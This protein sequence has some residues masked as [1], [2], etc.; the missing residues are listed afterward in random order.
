MGVR[1]RIR[2]LISL[3]YNKRLAWSRIN[4]IYE[5]IKNESNENVDKYI[6]FIRNIVSLDDSND[7]IRK[8]LKRYCKYTLTEH[9]I[10]KIDTTVTLKDKSEFLVNKYLTNQKALIL[11]EKDFKA[12]FKYQ[13]YNTGYSR[14][15]SIFIDYINYGTTY[16]TENLRLVDLDNLK[17]YEPH[18]QRLIKET[19]EFIEYDDSYEMPKDFINFI[20]LELN[21]VQRVVGRSALLTDENLLVCAPTGNGKTII[22]VMTIYRL[23]QENKNVKIAYIAP[24][25]SLSAEI[26]RFL[27]RIFCSMNIYECTSDTQ[28]SKLDVTNFNILVGTPEKIEI[29]MRNNP[30]LRFNL[31]ILDEIHVLNESR[32]HVIESIVMRSKMFKNCRL[33]GMSATIYNYEDVG[34]FLKCKAHNIFYFNESYRPVP[35]NYKIIQSHNYKIDL[36]DIINE[37]FGPYLIFVHT[38]KDTLE[39]AD[40]LCNYLNMTNKDK[41]D[42]SCIICQIDTEIYEKYFN[43]GIGIH[44]AGLSKAVKLKI[45]HLFKTGR[46][47]IMIGTS[48]LSYGI[49]LPISTVII[50]GT[51]FFNKNRNDYEVLSNMSIKQMLGR[52]GRDSSINCVCTGIDAWYIYKNLQN[53]MLDGSFLDM[54]SGFSIFKD[55]KINN[56][57]SQDYNYAIPCKS[58]VSKLYQLFI[59]G[60]ISEADILEDNLPRIF[61][62]IL[63]ISLYRKYYVSK[64][65]IEYYKSSLTRLFIYESPIKQISGEYTGPPISTKLLIK[66]CKDPGVKYIP[67]FIVSADFFDKYMK[68]SIL[69]QFDYS[70]YKKFMILIF[71]GDRLLIKDILYINHRESTKFYKIEKFKYYEINIISYDLI[72]CTY[73]KT[74]ERN[75]IQINYKLFRPKYIIRSKFLEFYDKIS[76]TVHK[77]KDKSLIL[78]STLNLLN[79]YKMY[80]QNV[81]HIN[82]LELDIDVDDIHII[83]EI[84]PLEYKNIRNLNI[85]NRRIYYHCDDLQMRIK[86]S[87]DF[88]LSSKISDENLRKYN[89]SEF[90][91]DYLMLHKYLYEDIDYDTTKVKYCLTTLFDMCSIKKYLKTMFNILFLIQR[92]NKFQ[93]KR[94]EISK[95]EDKLII[96][97]LEKYEDDDVNIYILNKDSEYKIIKLDFLGRKEVFCFMGANYVI[98]DH[99]KGYEIF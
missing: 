12:F 29:L 96:N 35:I 40:F 56:F 88:I 68:L 23:I 5:A 79:Y 77:I 16:S 95:S 6:N 47:N 4:I 82:N 65:A 7:S 71:N 69:T 62:C 2:K 9:D 52:A 37:I 86:K 81:Q 54:L 25:K 34:A 60:V 94:Y 32:G 43:Y 90:G 28:I 15:S 24:M 41:C 22:G 59:T 51:R 61:K 98:C 67:N 80:Y 74:V 13:I 19:G 66:M 46:L 3:K 45:E 26:Y 33:V 75:D 70:N 50:M 36:L 76:D 18:E 93:D 42:E 17:I 87:K 30:L 89:G 11:Y 73:K 99:C 21:Y 85:S 72:N 53:I 10:E 44:H 20:K 78:V 97:N 31:I 58:E 49:N 64:I 84:N 63:D 92:I 57:V 27:K 14:L 91:M 83:G 39:L 38:R 55:I 48:T 1:R 8:K